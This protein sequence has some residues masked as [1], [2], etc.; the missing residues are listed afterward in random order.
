[1]ANVDTENGEQAAKETKQLSPIEQL[2]KDSEA[3]LKEFRD[4]GKMP[5][6]TSPE[7][8]LIVRNKKM[9][10]DTQAQYTSTNQ[11][12]IA[13][14]A[15]K[16]TLASLALQVDTNY[17]AEQKSELDDLKFADPDAWFAKKQQY[18][19]E[20]RQGK[21]T[22]VKEAVTAATAKALEAQRLEQLKEF[23]STTGIVINDDV[24]AND[25]PPR[26]TQQLKEG[27][28]DFDQ[29]LKEASGFLTK[30]KVIQNAAEP[31]DAG[32]SAD[33]DDVTGTSTTNNVKTG[34]DFVKDYAEGEVDF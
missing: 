16:E 19:Q 2:D 24:I 6:G 30:G 13:T 12:L 34:T 8:A 14:K 29:F 11:E 7:M 26:I 25:I 22:K 33:F 18:D 28:I 20:A 27:K 9:A 3:V 10:R 17:T 31:G 15:E 1:M 5:E 32:A 23:T 4:S 21:E